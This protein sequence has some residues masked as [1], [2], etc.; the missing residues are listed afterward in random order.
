MDNLVGAA[1]GVKDTPQAK[2]IEVLKKEIKPLDK[3]SLEQFISSLKDNYEVN[4]HTS[5]GNALVHLE[6]AKQ[7]LNFN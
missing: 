1:W 6:Q 7:L 2:K 5:Y 4:R 3:I